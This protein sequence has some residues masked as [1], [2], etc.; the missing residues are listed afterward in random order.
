MA[1]VSDCDP[2]GSRM[3]S[4]ELLQ[5]RNCLESIAVKVRENVKKQTINNDYEHQFDNAQLAI[6]VQARQVAR[7]L[8]ALDDSEI[9]SVQGPNVQENYQSGTWVQKGTI[10]LLSGP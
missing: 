4:Y 9:L 1:P 7:A 2:G 8:L 5:Y 6:D 10:V 3:V